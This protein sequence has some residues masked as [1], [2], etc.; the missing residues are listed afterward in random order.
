MWILPGG[1]RDEGEDQL[2][3]VAREVREETGLTVRVERLLFDVPAQPADGTYVRW[4]T[5]ECTV[6]DGEAIPGGGE[7]ANAD[8]VDLAWFPLQN[9]HLWPNEI[10]IDAVLHPQLQ[11]IRV[12]LSDHRPSV[13]RSV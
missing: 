1:G 9:E 11:A 2:A 13:P 5:Y 10:T 12:A 3:C 6:L 4:R 8:L 7:G